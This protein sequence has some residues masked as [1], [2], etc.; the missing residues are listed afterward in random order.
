MKWWR[1]GKRAADVERELQSDLQLEEEEQRERG[2]DPE[3]ARYAALRA[4]GNPSVISEQTREVWS[5]DGLDTLLRDLRITMRTLARQAG[6]SAV[7]LLVIAV[8][9][10]ATISLFTVV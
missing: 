8:G 5:W 10:G 4:F 2:I 1:I 3:E 6:F 9:M 7:A